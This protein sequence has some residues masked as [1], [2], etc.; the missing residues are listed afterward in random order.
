MLPTGTVTFVFTDLEGSTRLWEQYPEVM[1]PALRRHDSIIGDAIA[2]HGGIVLRMT[3]DGMTSAFASA[4][5]AVAAA[6]DAQRSLVSEPWG[7]TGPLLVRIGVHTDEAV[8][9]DG[10]YLSPPLNRCSRLMSTAHGGQVVVSNTTEALVRGHLPTDAQ[11]ADLGPH[12]LR[13]LAEPLHVFQLAHPELESAF[14]PLRSL[15]TFAGNLPS[16]TTSFVGR[17]EEQAR[18]TDALDEARLVTVTGTGGVGKTRLALQVAAELLPEFPNGSWLCE[19]AVASDGESM[20]QAVATTLRVTPSVDRTLKE[21]ILDNLRSRNALVVLDN[22]EHL[23]DAVGEL[24]EAIVRSSPRVRVLA[25]SREALDVPGEHVIRLRSLPIPD[26]SNAESI[27][28]N[29]AAQ[30]FI[31]RARAAEAGFSLTSDDDAHAVAEIC[32]RLDGIPLAIEL[33]AARVV[34]MSPAEIAGLLDERF[35]LLAGGRRAT[36]ERHQTLR[37]TVEWSYA[38]LTERERLVFDR[39]G[40]FPGSFDGEGARAVAG[41]G[42]DDWDV[43]EALAGLVAKSMLLADRVPEGTRYQVLETLRHFARE[44]LDDEGETDS[45]RRVHA[46]HYTEFTEAVADQMYGR[47]EVAARQRLRRDVDN[48]RAAVM[49]ALDSPSADDAELAVRIVAALGQQAL[50]EPSLGVGAWAEHAVASAEH[51]TR[52]QRAV[53]FATASCNARARGDQNTASRLAREALRDGLGNE[54]RHPILVYTARLMTVPNEE[55]AAVLADARRVL[56]GLAA[57][58]PDFPRWREEEQKLLSLNASVAFGNGDIAAARTAA[59][60]HAAIARDLESGTALAMSAFLR[61]S[62]RLRDQPEVALAALE[63]SIELTRAG[64]GGPAYGTALSL[65]ARLRLHAGDVAGA[66]ANLFEAVEYARSVQRSLLTIV[67][68]QGAEFVAS[69]GHAHAVPVLVGAAESRHTTTGIV[70]WTLQDTPTRSAW[71]DPVRAELGSTRFD[72]AAAR[73]A[74]MSDDE[75]IAYLV[76]SLDSLIPAD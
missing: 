32:R 5:D 30:L 40:V 10:E 3:G 66:R 68:D 15:D 2:R 45:R 17:E 13:D 62:T 20:L 72:A 31:E 28:H 4:R 61:G 12:R 71:L 69:L 35:R 37:A 52:D 47:E 27:A 75:A 36:V 44:Q 34:T 54:C 8:V 59:D 1:Q 53:V 39:L 76:D 43:R 60:E 11:L 67:L 64:A 42:L 55:A 51:S 18:V 73:G 46:R 7:E 33:A 6:L 41:E 25:T 74:T 70:S 19:L 29:S 9:H 56:D 22:C 24:A 49:W 48:V 21:S 57:A 14:P 58:A 50:A 26:A 16:Q 23:L 65:M 38:L 63:E